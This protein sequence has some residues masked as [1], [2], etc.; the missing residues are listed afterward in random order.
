M[1]TSV[2]KE[3]SS[4]HHGWQGAEDVGGD[5]GE[6]FHLLSCEFT[7]GINPFHEERLHSSIGV[8]DAGGCHRG[9]DALVNL[10]LIF[11]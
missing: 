11:L 4:R 9:V 10:I 2:V 8:D 3:P 6:F 7:V 1:D 5:F